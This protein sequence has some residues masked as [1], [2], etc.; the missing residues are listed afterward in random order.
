[1]FF[2][3]T[4]PLHSHPLLLCFSFC[5]CRPVSPP[6]PHL[7]ICLFS[8]LLSSS[9]LSPWIPL[10]LHL[11]FSHHTFQLLPSLIL[12][13]SSIHPLVELSPVFNIAFASSPLPHLLSL[14]PSYFV[15]A[16]LRERRVPPHLP[17]TS[18]AP[19]CQTVQISP[20]GWVSAV[21]STQGSSGAP[22]TSRAPPTPAGLRPHHYHMATARPGGHTVPQAFSAS[23]HPNLYAGEWNERQ[24]DDT[25]VAEQ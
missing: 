19:L 1:M 22:E 13:A 23:S 24:E 15:V 6:T 2:F 25:V 16:Q 3:L 18:A 21:H 5:F 17:T 4:P 12:C 20:E 8:C 9:V 11:L 10:Y 7:F 14:F